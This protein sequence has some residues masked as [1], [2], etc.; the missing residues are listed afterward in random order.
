MA[1]HR[2]AGSSKNSGAAAFQQTDYVAI[3]NAGIAQG[4]RWRGAIGFLASEQRL[5]GAE[6][7]HPGL[8]SGD[9][10]GLIG[11]QVAVQL[12]ET[13]GN[14]RLECSYIEAVARRGQATDCLPG[15]PQE[16]PP[17]G[18]GRLRRND[19]PQPKRH[20]GGESRGNRGVEQPDRVINHPILKLAKRGE[21]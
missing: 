15:D 3:G 18:F 9:I 4:D 13:L 5:P 14:S 7:T 17:G 6:E 19:G 21:Q 16:P 11:T 8:E 10:A 20:A 12:V 1:D 2:L